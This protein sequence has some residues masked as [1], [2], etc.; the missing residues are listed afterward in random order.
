MQE[1][2]FIYKENGG[3]RIVIKKEERSKGE[4]IMFT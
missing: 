3:G 4:K 1:E 2:I